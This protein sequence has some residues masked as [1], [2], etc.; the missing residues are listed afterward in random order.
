MILQTVI[1]SNI[2][3]I[4]ASFS[5][6]ESRQNLHFVLSTPASRE[7]SPCPRPRD[8]LE[9]VLEDIVEDTSPPPSDTPAAAP[10]RS[11]SAAPRGT[12]A[13]ARTR[14]ASSTCPHANNIIG[15]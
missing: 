6:C 15:C 3:Y 12:A 7:V 14:A 5:V 13:A 1:H 8:I 2:N 10:P 4:G 9:A 11:L